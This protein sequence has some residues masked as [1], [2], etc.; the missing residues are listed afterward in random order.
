LDPG[1]IRQEGLLDPDPILVKWHEHLT[2]RRDRVDHLWPVLMFRSWLK[3]HGTGVVPRHH[4]PGV[5]LE[6]R[7]ALGV[8]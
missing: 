2:G 7:R 8:H 4:G 5:V 1:C 6:D 3:H